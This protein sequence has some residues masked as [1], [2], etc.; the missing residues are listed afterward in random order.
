MDC[1]KVQRLFDEFADGRLA[2]PLAEQLQRHLTDCTDCRVAQ[3]RAA[4]L[5]RLL[6]LKRYEQPAPAYFHGFLDEF[7]RRLQ[8]ETAATHASLWMWLKA[9]WQGFQ[10]TT[11]P[12]WVLRYGL[13]GATGVLLM[14]GVASWMVVHQPKPM[15]AKR[16]AP[17][18]SQNANVSALPARGSPWIAT[19]EGA[20]AFATLARDIPTDPTTPVVLVPAPA[21]METSTP[22]YVLDHLAITP[23]SY[24]GPRVDF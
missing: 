11:T 10:T 18:A 24:E 19:Q 2:A 3:Q 6:A 7:H 1:R 5:L 9:Q 17:P 15:V 20:M 4:R 21:R 14:M 23:A 16:T 8:V 13:A 12:V 22:R